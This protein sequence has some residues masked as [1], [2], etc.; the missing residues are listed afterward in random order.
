MYVPVCTKGT[1]FNLYFPFHL[2]GTVVES[3]L[4]LKKKHFSD[5]RRIVTASNNSPGI[6]LRM[7]IPKHMEY[8]QRRG[9]PFHMPNGFR[10]PVQLVRIRAKAKVNITS[11]DVDS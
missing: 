1:F 9:I 11:L 3:S 10:G 4:I 6:E 7:N 8:C 5:D 2:R